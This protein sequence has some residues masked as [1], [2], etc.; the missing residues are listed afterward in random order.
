MLHD[1]QRAKEI[2]IT[3]QVRIVQQH[4]RKRRPDRTAL[5]VV[6]GP[7]GDEKAP[8]HVRPDDHLVALCEITV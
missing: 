3:I 7:V 4:K 8:P 6:W 2:E 5:E 1:F